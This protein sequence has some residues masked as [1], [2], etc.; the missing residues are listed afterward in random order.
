MKFLNCHLMGRVGNQLFQ[1]AACRAFAEKHEMELRTPP[2]LGQQIFELHDPPITLQAGPRFN[3]RTLQDFGQVDF[4]GYGQSQMALDWYT[5]ADCRR[6]F[7][8]RPE[9]LEA[10]KELKELRDKLSGSTIVGHVRRG[11]YLT[12][13]GYVIVSRNSYIRKAAE[14]GFSSYYEINEEHPT[15]LHA[16]SLPTELS[17]LP[18]FYWMTLAYI[19]LRANSSF[20][21]WAHTLAGDSQR[22]FAPVIE[23]K[24]GGVESDCEFVE[25]SW[26]RLANLDVCTD[27]HLRP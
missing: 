2:W 8:W 7:T 15:K 17:F 3:E 16:G 26:P 24:P 4:E 22:I 12:N 5:R 21:W 13:G 9:I 18:D 11:D 23:G 10:L 19:L 25:G 20:S 1:Y 27:L 6:W 14:L